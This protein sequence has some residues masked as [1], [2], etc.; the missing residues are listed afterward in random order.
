MEQSAPTA[1]V[2]ES[3]VLTAIQKV[4]DPE[5]PVNV[6]DLGLIYDIKI[7]DDWVG[8]KMTLTTPGCGMGAA[9]TQQVRESVLDIP[10]VNEC[11]VRLV[12]EPAWDPSMMSEP[13]KQKLGMA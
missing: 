3:V 11:D 9:I 8:V 5:V 13:A 4:Y 7:I 2:T 6:V 12:W 1:G 10:G